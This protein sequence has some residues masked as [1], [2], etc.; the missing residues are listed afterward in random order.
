MGTSDT[1]IED[2]GRTKFFGAANTAGL[3]DSSAAN[4][5]M[6]LE[7]YINN[8]A[9]AATNDGATLASLVA[10]IA[11]L[12]SKLNTTVPPLMIQ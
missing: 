10:Q 5:H 3:F 11:A 6:Q 4:T 1:S 12:T 2:L 9:N 7:G 8:L